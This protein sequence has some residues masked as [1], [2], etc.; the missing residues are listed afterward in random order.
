M[1][2]REERSDKRLESDVAARIE[3][4]GHRVPV[5]VKDLSRR[6]ARLEIPRETLC[7]EEGAELIA[8]AE[9][10]N[11]I[12]P[13]SF[14]VVFGDDDQGDALRRIAT[15]VR[16]GCHRKG[17]RMVQVGC[18]LDPPLGAA[19]AARLEVELPAAPGR[20]PSRPARIPT[21]DSTPARKGHAWRNLTGCRAY[22]KG[23]PPC[24]RPPVQGWA[25]RASRTRIVIRLPNLSRLGLSATPSDAPAFLHELTKTFG[26]A[27]TCKVLQ[28][29]THLWSGPATV[30]EIEVDEKD[31][32]GGRVHLRY[33][34]TLR[35][36]EMRA[37]GV[38][39]V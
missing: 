2:G 19:D 1:L 3:V 15:P 20:E 37:L 39:L 32:R 38:D 6:G 34:R 16:L 7:L 13:G 10:F 12:L 28:G 25:E 35:P 22:L 27:L 21:D 33:R 18:R 29:A 17:S 11:R 23:T 5:R 31:A 30:A 24:T 36:A 14:E 4:P 9:A 8:V 26:P